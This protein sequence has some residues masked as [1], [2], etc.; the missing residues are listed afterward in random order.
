MEITRP[1]G[2]VNGFVLVQLLLFHRLYV[3]F[4]YP[5]SKTEV[6]GKHSLGLLGIL[7]GG[8]FKG[9][10]KEGHF[11][12]GH[13]HLGGLRHSLPLR[14]RGHHLGEDG[15]CLRCIQLKARGLLQELTHRTDGA[16]VFA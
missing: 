10:N 14:Q 11:S 4:K 12:G 1:S 2:S 5:H 7:Q 16:S 9:G 6:L 13:A 3:H 15:F 8:V